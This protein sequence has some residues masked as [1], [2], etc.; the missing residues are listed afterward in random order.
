MDFLHANDELGVH[1]K[2]WYSATSV[3]DE[4][5]SLSSEISCD[6][7][8][9]GAGFTGLSAA[10]HLAEAG[11]SVALLEAHR[12][13]WGASGRNGGQ[14]GTGFNSPETLIDRLG[15]ETALKLWRIAED[16][17]ATVH[18]ICARHDIDCD[19]K[20]GIVYA[21]R[22]KNAHTKASEFCSYFKKEYGYEAT[23]LSHKQILEHVNSA[24]YQA[25]ILDSGAGH[26][27]PL[28]LCH[29]LAKAASAKGAAL[30]ELSKAN[31]II[32]P[33]TKDSR[34]FVNT[35]AGS[36]KAD[37]LIIACNGY[38][39]SLVPVVTSY[40]FPINNFIIATEPLGDLADELLPHN[41]AVSDDRFV[42]NYFR[43]TKDK[44]LV[45]GG[46]ETYSAVFPSDIE[47]RVRRAMLKIFPALS[48][49]GT[50]HAWGGTLAITHNRLP[51]VRELQP[52]VY[53]A[54]GYSGH[55]VALATETGK[56]IA[57]K[58]CG[59]G[60]RFQTMAQLSHRSFP[61][62]P[63]VR[64]GILKFSMSAAA[65]LDRF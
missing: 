21:L 39:D 14:L 9:I 63:W 36:V 32:F 3:C 65:L 30:Y 25:G 56:M 12:V 34:I 15:Q 40:V 33:N 1:A 11:Q 53:T 5:P 13:G 49:V 52:N 50:A 20:P 51:F 57:D 28:K 47:K 26:L 8:I 35:S 10:L 61:R 2:S 54:G 46:G 6:V 18:Q 41:N 59:E 45:F 4:Y 17:K 62:N 55:G 16:A 27:H 19:Y 48:E 38:L 37:S 42:V 29:G 22:G 31:D 24:H 7:C 43:Q 23:A 44:R 58:I 64:S 60:E